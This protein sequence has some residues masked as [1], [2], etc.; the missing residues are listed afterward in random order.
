LALLLAGAAGVEDKDDEGDDAVCDDDTAK[1]DEEGDD[2]DMD[3]LILEE[4][5]W[6]SNERK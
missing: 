3:L 5:E 1:E 2:G 6:N 4:M